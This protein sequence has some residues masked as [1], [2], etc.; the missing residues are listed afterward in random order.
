MQLSQFAILSVFAALSATTHAIRPSSDVAAKVGD[1]CKSITG[2]QKRSCGWSNC[3][4]CYNNQWQCEACATGTGD[5]WGD[6]IVCANWYVWIPY[7]TQF[8]C[9]SEF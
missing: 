7:Q 6:L 8:S 5:P 3:D 1:I 2:V 9:T 4:D